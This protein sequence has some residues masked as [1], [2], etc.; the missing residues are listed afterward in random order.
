MK[1][2]FLSF[3]LAVV[4]ASAQ[5]NAVYNLWQLAP[6]NTQERIDGIPTNWIWQVQFTDETVKPSEWTFLTNK[7]GYL[8]YRSSVEPSVDAWRQSNAV[9]AATQRIYDTTFDRIISTVTNLDFPSV[10]GQTNADLTMNVFGV[11]GGDPIFI[12]VGGAA[13]LPNI[14]YFAWTTSTN[15]VTIRCLNAGTQARNPGNAQFRVTVMKFS[16]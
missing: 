6:T 12:S 15:T 16:N 3:L 9:A 14:G 13:I 2:L 8:A 7:A 11:S 4:S 10:A 5:T 1:T